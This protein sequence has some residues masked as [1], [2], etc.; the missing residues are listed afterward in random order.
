MPYCPKCGLRVLEEDAKFCPNCGA[1]LPQFRSEGRRIAWTGTLSQ[2]VVVFLVIFILC[3]LATLAG[4][5]TKVDLLSARN[6]VDKMD[7]IEDVLKNT[8][9]GVQLIFG[10]NL[11][12]TLGMFIPIAGPGLGFYVLYNTGLV[13]SAL[14]TIYRINP[15]LTFL[16][17]F[18]FPHAWMEYIAYTL[19]I[20][21]SLWLFYAAIKRRFRDELIFMSIVVVICSVLLLF[22]ALI[23][24]AIIA[25]SY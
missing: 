20:S 1:T 11:M 17:L 25:A 15:L 22:G 14:S 19:A 21:E 24:A 4:A 13:I 10:N 7:K 6:I 8:D 3:I 9:I 5:L 12:Y 2:R 16:S 18:I 23:E